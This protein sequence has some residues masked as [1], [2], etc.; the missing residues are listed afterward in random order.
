VAGRRREPR[1]PARRRTAVAA[2][3]AAAA[4]ALLAAALP[5]PACGPWFPNTLLP[6]DG[7]A[8]EAPLNPF[9]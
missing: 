3:A 8:L 1:A 6:E 9:L 4:L 2:V 7:A 5:A